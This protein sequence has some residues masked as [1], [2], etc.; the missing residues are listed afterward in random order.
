MVKSM[1]NLNEK[2]NVEKFLA[3]LAFLKKKSHGYLSKKSKVFTTDEIENYLNVFP[4]N[5]HLDKKV[6]MIFGIFGALRSDELVKVKVEHV[7]KQGEIYHVIVPVTKNMMPRSLTITGEFCKYVENYSKLRP[8][9]ATEDRF[10]L[11]FQNGKC[12]VQAI[13]KNKFASTL[14]KIVEFLQL[15]DPK[16]YTG[17]SFRRSSA[18]ILVDAGADLTVLKR[19]GGWKSSTVAEGYIEESLGNKRKISSLYCNAINLPS[20]SDHSENSASPNSCLQNL[21]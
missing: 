7:K 13:G 14:Q 6:I 18:T 12:T 11:N 1:I 10:F 2:I 3:I 15:P 20:T 16:E 19:H 9:L 21:H 17:H 5:Q 8:K 4:D